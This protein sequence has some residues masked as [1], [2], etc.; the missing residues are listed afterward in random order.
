MVK[1]K[2]L[3]KIDKIISKMARTYWQ[4]THKYRLHIPHTVKEAI[5]INKEHE[6]ILWWDAINRK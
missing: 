6:D 5:E 3:K 1:N 4:K 2:V